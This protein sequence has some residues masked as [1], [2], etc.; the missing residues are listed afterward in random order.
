MV[1]FPGILCSQKSSN[2]YPNMW[3]DQAEW[4]NCLPYFK[5]SFRYGCKLVTHCLQKLKT[6]WPYVFLIQSYIE[7]HNKTIKYKGIA[8]ND[9]VCLEIN[10]PDIR[11]ILLG[12]VTYVWQYLS[13]SKLSILQC[14][15]RRS[16]F[17]KGA[18]GRKLIFS[19]GKNWQNL[20]NADKLP[21]NWTPFDQ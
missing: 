1:Q 2:I 11:V 8:Y 21:E 6:P 15:E 18:E 7:L 3:P 16:I 4:V 9:W 20:S 13:Y 17:W 19:K 10:I 14:R 5:M 12:Q